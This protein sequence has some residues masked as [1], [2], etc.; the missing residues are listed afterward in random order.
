[1]INSKIFQLSVLEA[2]NANQVSN[3]FYPESH[4]LVYKYQGEAQ[5]LKTA[6]RHGFC[7]ITCL[8]LV[9]INFVNISLIYHG[10]NNITEKNRYHR[11]TDF[12]RILNI[13]KLNSDLT[14]N[15]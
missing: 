10:N 11:I 2:I 4:I 5:I 15:K 1:M 13:A 9:L 7:F 12:L 14:L 8:E 6:F 3:V